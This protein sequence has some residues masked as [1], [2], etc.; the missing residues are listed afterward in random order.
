MTISIII[1]CY[2]AAKYLPVIIADIKSQTYSDWELIIVS[3]GPHQ[4]EQITVANRFASED[5]R[6][7]VVVLDTPGVSNARNTGVLH[8]NGD[9]V[10]F[11]DADDRLSNNHLQRFVSVLDS[12]PDVVCGGFIL[13]R[14]S[15]NSKVEVPLASLDSGNDGM[16]A[17]LNAILSSSMILN[18]LW[19]KIF[20]LDF[21]RSTECVFPM[22]ITVAEDHI[23]VAEVLLK[24]S[25]VK[26]IPMTGYIYM[27]EDGSSA[28]SRYH[29]CFS[30]AQRRC[31]P[32]DRQLKIKAGMDEAKIDEDHLRSAYIR[33]Y[34][35]ICNIFK[36]GCDLTFSQKCELIRNWI[37]SSDFE[38]S[39]AM[40]DAS[41][42]NL[43]CK[44]FDISLIGR[45]AHIVACSFALQYFVKRHLGPFKGTL[46]RHLRN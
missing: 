37:K 10:M 24:S 39:F 33:V 14:V 16:G 20:N 12:H 44:L 30:E 27:Y 32:L 42:H 35:E 26:T 11:V 31:D 4:E 1:P 2:N 34:F 18:N 19:N 13:N 5:S 36:K 23:F 41:K 15:E 3:N 28:M 17:V 21:L 38:K 43:L 40:Q 25:N 9:Y 7:K 45:S 29:A 6:I 8:A 22:D 46:M